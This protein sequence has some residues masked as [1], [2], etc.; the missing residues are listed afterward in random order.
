MIQP[1]TDG[2]RVRR[3]VLGQRERYHV[4]G[5][6]LERCGRVVD[7]L[8]GLEERTHG[9]PRRVSGR[10][11]RR[12]HV[13]GPG[14]VVTERD[15][16]VRPDEHRAGV[17]NLGRH[18]SCG[19][20][21]NLEMLSGVGVHDVQP[22]GQ[23]IDHDDR[24]LGAGQ[25]GGHAL[26][27]FGQRNLL[28]QLALDAL[29]QGLRIR[30]QH[31]CRQGVVLGLAD[32][33]GRHVARL[34]ALVCQH[35]YLGGTR[36]GVDADHAPQQPLGRYAVDV[37][38]PC[39][40]VDR[41][42]GLAL[43]LEAEGEH[44][45]RAGS[46][47]GVDL[48]DA[49]ECAGTEDRGVREPAV[50][51]L[52][53]TGQCERCHAS[54]LG[55]HDV[56]QHRGDQ[57]CRGTGNIEADPPDGYVAAGHTSASR[58]YGLHVF[59]ELSLASRAK[60]RHRLL[61]AATDLGVETV[62]RGSKGVPG[63]PYPGDLDTVEHRGLADELA[64]TVAP[65]CLDQGANL[66]DDV[67]DVHGSTWHQRGV[68][69]RPVGA[70]GPTDIAST[71]HLSS[72]ETENWL[73]DERTVGENALMPPANPG[74]SARPEIAHEQAHLTESRAALA[75]MRDRTASME[76]LSGDRVSAE[77][78][79]FTLW[80]RMKAL[81][82]DP[83]IPLF[84][85]RLDYGHQVEGSAGLPGERFYIGRRHVTDP[86]GDP[87]VV[88]WRAPIS[89]PFYRA[90]RAEPMGLRLRRRFGFQHGVVTAYEDESMT[91]PSSMEAPL[92]GEGAVHSEILEA[93][94]ERPRVGPM[95]D[96]VATI[97]PEQD[98]IVRSEL[99]TS[100]CVQGAPGTGKTAVGLHRAAYLL[101]AH[102]DQ[103]SR[104]GVL[105]VGPNDSFL[106]YIGDVLP[107]LGEI[108][109]R[110][111][112]VEALV[113]SV[114]IRGV[115]TVEAARIKGD[116]RMAVV[117]ERALWGMVTPASEALVVPS[118]VRRWRVAAYLID[119]IVQEL[120]TRG[121]RYGAGRAMLPQRLAHAVLV[122]MEE[123]GD[124]PD[125]RVHASV[126]R[127]RPVKE[128]STAVWP[129]VDAARLVMRLLGEP[130]LL[131]AAADGILS[132][133][134]AGSHPVASRGQRAA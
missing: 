71:D 1:D 12:Q 79:K 6:E 86:E 25:R 5:R 21:V 120:R 9:Q 131:A 87:L 35:E 26:R 31:A 84:F 46:T 17:A 29:G 68:A 45:H 122:K 92:Q 115:D 63:H 83:D 32:Q 132:R 14:A 70:R 88:D 50:L 89:R 101:Y 124:S 3:Q 114:P 62:Q 11:S 4:A 76:A 98:D 61:D 28:L 13:V 37:G 39:H 66:L 60:P 33:V 94:I 20:G 22:L 56:H 69:D 102:R 100:V 43:V 82:D 51:A 118:G 93:E 47:C 24:G 15:R 78:L 123:A 126:A 130:D 127:S 40:E 80:K 72:I 49:Q 30:D 129:V 67:V 116:A 36:L 81:E 96:I 112:T 34:G 65:Y 48:L 109:A 134:G 117:L 41:F 113:E 111:T 54:H 38:W 18:G 106:R 59:R 95:R 77:Y 121:V 90:S 105:V 44:G 125:D 55:G 110:Q 10:S 133:R 8:H 57:G 119:E 52:G 97:Q 53:W 7:D 107:A 103:L 85:G 104:Q 23:V 64:V 19:S 108:D 128:L 16:R 99:D 74:D 91:G 73:D 58:E 2:V 75:R 42:A 27:V